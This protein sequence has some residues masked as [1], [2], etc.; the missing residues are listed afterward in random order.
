MNQ[1]LI[2]N[3][4]VIRNRLRLFK[5]EILIILFELIKKIVV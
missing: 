1:H 5:S 2:R 3:V 4:F